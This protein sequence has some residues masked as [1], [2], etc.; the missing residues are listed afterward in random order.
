MST[1]PQDLKA[2]DKNNMAR[3]SSLKWHLALAALEKF[4]QV[5]MGQ[6]SPKER[7]K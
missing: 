6:G 1:H 2:Q 3:R 5:D 4:R 7:E